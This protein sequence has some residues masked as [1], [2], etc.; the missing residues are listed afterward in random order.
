MTNKIWATATIRTPHDESFCVAFFKKRPPIQGR[1]ALGRAR[2]RETFLTPFLVLFA[3]I[4]PKR[5]ESIFSHKQ[6]GSYFAQATSL[7]FYIE[8]IISVLFEQRGPKRTKKA[9]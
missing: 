6:K 8:R 3:A 1:E 4:L 7:F 9:D 2:R 5:T